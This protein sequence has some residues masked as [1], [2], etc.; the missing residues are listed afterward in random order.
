MRVTE[1]RGERL[2]RRMDRL[3]ITAVDLARAAG[4]HRGAVAR[5]RAGQARSATFGTLE[6]VLDRLEHETHMDAPSVDDVVSTVE[7]PDGTRATFAG[8]PDGV[9]KAVEAFLRAHDEPPESG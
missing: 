9:A 1:Q 6:A 5:A 8:P 4:I 2:A 7:F 3:G